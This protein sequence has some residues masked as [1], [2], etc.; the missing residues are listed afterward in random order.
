MWARKGHSSPPR[1]VNPNL[2]GQYF[3]LTA[4]SIHLY[5]SGTTNKAAKC[6][7]CTCPLETEW[8]PSTHFTQV[9]KQQSKANGFLSPPAQGRCKGRPGGERL[10]IP[11]PILGTIW[12]PLK[13]NLLGTKLK[14][15]PDLLFSQC[16]FQ[17]CLK[18]SKVA[19]LMGWP[20]C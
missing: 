16:C 2:A 7:P 20:L 18:V 13:S 5:F 10:C 6:D 19:E 1:K 4:Y 9:S 12:S 8:E 17:K 3:N 11:L 14:V 15:L